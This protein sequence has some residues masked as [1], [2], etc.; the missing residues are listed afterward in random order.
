MLFSG[1][2]FLATFSPAKA[3]RTYSSAMGRRAA[4]WYHLLPGQAGNSEDTCDILARPQAVSAI[5][6]R[7]NL[8]GEQIYNS[9]SWS[10]KR[11]LAQLQ[12]DWYVLMFVGY[13]HVSYQDAVLGRDHARA[14]LWCWGISWVWLQQKYLVVSLH[15]GEISK[16][17]NT[18][19]LIIK[20]KKLSFHPPHHLLPLTPLK[21]FKSVCIVARDWSYDCKV[22]I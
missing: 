1:V 4:R 9:A 20:M 14:S 8:E 2:G 16:S 7:P 15:L 17:W 22:P 19:K 12:K 11:S 21:D 3:P 18:W 10:W 6:T 5:R 13:P